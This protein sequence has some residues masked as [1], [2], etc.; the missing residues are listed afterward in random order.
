MRYKFVVLLMLIILLAGCNKIESNIE[1]E[2]SLFSDRIIVDEVKE[3]DAMLAFRVFEENEMIVQEVLI[4]K[5]LTRREVRIDLIKILER[6]DEK[7]DKVIHINLNQLVNENSS[8][9]GDWHE[10]DT[11]KMII[12]FIFPSEFKI[13]S[14]TLYRNIMHMIIR[15]ET[16]PEHG[17][18]EVIA[19][20]TITN[21][22]IS[23]HDFPKDTFH[24]VYE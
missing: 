24:F 16:L 6:L 18:T 9:I 5:N 4:W 2:S 1:F 23:S 21:I 15:L 19:I 13:S 7:N 10:S 11:S 20:S 14:E 12:E 17:D 22:S 3:S 8:D